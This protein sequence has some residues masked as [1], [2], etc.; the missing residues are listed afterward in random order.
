MG[1]F[2]KRFTTLKVKQFLKQAPGTKWELKSLARSKLKTK[3]PQELNQQLKLKPGTKSSVSGTKLLTLP[4]EH[5][6]WHY[7]YAK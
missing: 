3:K 6:S 1:N 2:F 4:N 7:P 5:L